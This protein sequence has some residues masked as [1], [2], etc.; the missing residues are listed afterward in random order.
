MVPFFCHMYSRR[1]NNLRDLANIPPT[2]KLYEVGCMEF[3]VHYLCD[4]SLLYCVIQS[5]MKYRTQ[6]EE[7]L[8]KFNSLT[9]TLRYVLG[10]CYS[11]DR[12]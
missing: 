7:T 2:I 9:M 3:D 10:Y 1:R 6:V 8:P 4:Y 11:D 12:V 5:L